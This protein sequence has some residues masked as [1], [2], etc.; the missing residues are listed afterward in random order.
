MEVEEFE[1]IPIDM[2]MITIPRQKYAAAEFKGSN[3][4]IFQAYDELHQWAED[5]SYVRL[6]NTWHLEIF[7]SWEDQDNLQVELLD[8]VR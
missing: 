7:Q 4:Q 2:V 8:T 6:K 3:Q 5:N 1:D